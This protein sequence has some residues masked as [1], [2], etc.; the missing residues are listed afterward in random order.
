MQA[1]SNHEPT[2]PPQPARGHPA[3][4]APATGGSERAAGLPQD[5]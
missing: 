2:V 4:P 1:G 5:L 3:T